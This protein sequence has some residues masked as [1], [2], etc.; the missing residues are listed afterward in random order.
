MEENAARPLPELRRRD[1]VRCRLARHASARSAPRRWSPTPAQPADQAAGAAA[2][3]ARRRSRRATAM[4]AGW[5][6][7]VRAERPEGYARRAAGMH[8]IYVPYWT[9]DAAN[10]DRLHRPA[11]RSTTRP[12]SRVVV[13]RHSQRGRSRSPHPLAAGA[14]PGGRVL[15]RRA[16]ARP[17]DAAEALHRRAGAVGSAARSPPTAPLSRRASAPRAITSRCDEGYAEARAIMDEVIEQDIRR[18]IGGDQQRISAKHHGRR[19]VPSS[20][21]CC[22]SGSR[23]TGTAAAPSASWSTAAPARSRANGPGQGRR[24]PLACSPR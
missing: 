5:A 20:T 10:P 18:D 2:V 14:R 8:G 12:F 1:R 7:L 3:R 22:R 16:G 23:P 17:R 21:C 24:S 6:A 11:R 19:D 15:R 13:R 9:Y 4:T